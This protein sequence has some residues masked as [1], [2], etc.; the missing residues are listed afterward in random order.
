MKA[1]EV[2]GPWGQ[3]WVVLSPVPTVPHTH[4][5]STPFVK[6]LIIAKRNKREME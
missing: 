3:Q 4:M 6:L 1:S 2:P 5:T